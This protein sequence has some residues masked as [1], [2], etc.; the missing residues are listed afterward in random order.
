MSQDPLIRPYIR[1]T[2]P[3][4]RSGEPLYII[5]VRDST[6][7][8]KLSKWTKTSRSIAAR[9]EDNRM[10]IFDH[11]TLSLFIVTWTHSWDNMVIWDPWLKRHINI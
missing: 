4:L 10:H 5:I 11:N 1:M 3:I 9:V 6:A 8:D 7:N 2:L